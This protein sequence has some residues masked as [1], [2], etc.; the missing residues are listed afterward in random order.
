MHPSSWSFRHSSSLEDMCNY[1][2]VLHYHLDLG[3]WT[4]FEFPACGG[5]SGQ[6]LVAECYQ[7]PDVM[8]ARCPA[9]SCSVN[10]AASLTVQ[11]PA[12]YPLPSHSIAGTTARFL[13]KTL[14]SDP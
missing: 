5:S 8:H 6:L 14:S 12:I 9:L 11:T 13:Q 2:S 10:A 1:P 3:V 7:T 4:M